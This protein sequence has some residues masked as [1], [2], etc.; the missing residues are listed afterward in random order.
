M[1]FTITSHCVLVC[2]LLLT[3]LTPPGS[4]SASPLRATL[5]LASRDMNTFSIHE[6]KSRWLCFFSGGMQSHRKIKA[7]SSNKAERASICC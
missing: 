2:S 3:F 4:L 1:N 5:S 6:L 7:T